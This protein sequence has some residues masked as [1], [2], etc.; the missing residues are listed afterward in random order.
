MDGRRNPT[1]RG[2][3]AAGA[4]GVAGVAGCI[5]G[6]G[7]ETLAVG[8]VPDVD[9]ETAIAQSEG[10]ATHLESELGVTVELSTAASYGGMVR[11]MVAEEVDVA[12][13]GGVSYILAHHRAGAEAFAV[14]VKGGR[15]KWH[16]AFVVPADGDVESMDDLTA[17]ADELDLVFGDPLST[18]GTVMPSYFL[19]TEHD[20][21]PEAFASTTHVGAHDATARAIDNAS[22]DVGALNARIYDALD[23]DGSL[24]NV[25]ELWR[26]PAFPDYPWTVAPTVGDERAA[27]LK[28]AFVSLEDDSV[29]EEQN[30]D[31]YTGASHDDFASL[32]EA[33]SMAGLLEE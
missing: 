21:P 18:S 15:T 26:T 27:A 28:E 11:S 19:R 31:G 3:L 8:I 2:F 30:V 6:D 10:L 25:R 9:P 29:L 32:S 24:D 23:A 22:G 13:Y 7:G 1:R 12:Y 17:R 5:G 14:G 20:T 4:A 16:S 33:V